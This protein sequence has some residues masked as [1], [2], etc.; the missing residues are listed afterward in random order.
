M[1][2]QEFEDA[3]KLWKL[4]YAEQCFMHAQ[5]AAEYILRNNIEDNNPVFY[6]LI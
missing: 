1:K 5:A 2:P 6:S 4:F 3:K